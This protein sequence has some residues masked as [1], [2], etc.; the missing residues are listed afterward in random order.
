MVVELYVMLEEVPLF[1]FAVPAGAVP[2]EPTVIVIVPP[3]NPVIIFTADP[4]PLPPPVIVDAA[5][6]PLPPPPITVT[7]HTVTPVGTAQLKVPVP[8]L[9]SD[10]PLLLV[11]VVG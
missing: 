9:V 4:P 5:E 6:A 1:P 7:L 3:D 8:V 2:P 11:T 10:E